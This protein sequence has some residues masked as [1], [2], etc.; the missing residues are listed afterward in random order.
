MLTTILV[1]Q[2]NVR[3]IVNIIKRIELATSTPHYPK[4]NSMAENAVE[5]SKMLL[6]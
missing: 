6:Q 4:S 1:V 2:W 3:N 5:L